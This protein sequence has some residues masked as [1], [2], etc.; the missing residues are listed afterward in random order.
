M[1]PRA[2]KGSSQTKWLLLEVTRTLISG[3]MFQQN[4]IPL[5]F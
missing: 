2:S 1:I 3:A 5:T 4:A